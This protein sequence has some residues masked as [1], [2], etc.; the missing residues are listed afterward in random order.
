MTRYTSGLRGEAQAEAYLEAR[1]MTCL[2]RRYR[3]A[4]G[5]L[6]LIMEDGETVV[7]VEVKYRPQSRAGE[8]L[9]AVTPNKRQ[10]M[11]HAALAYLT[12]K[13]TLDR[14]A[15]F[16]AVEITRDGVLHIP[17]AFMIE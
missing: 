8:G 10:R 12:E 2:E 15:R 16:D 14:P 6:D 5:E 17:N 4:D 1:G 7:F 3:A 9:R 11:I 13:Q